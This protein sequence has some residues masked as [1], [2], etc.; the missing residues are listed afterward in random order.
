MGIIL[1][2]RSYLGLRAQG[3]GLSLGLG[4]RSA[5]ILSNLPSLTAWTP[6]GFFGL[7]LRF[8]FRLQSS[9]FAF[10]SSLF[11]LHIYLDLLPY[12]L[13]PTFYYHFYSL[14]L[15]EPTIWNPRALFV[16]VT[17]RRRPN[18]GDWPHLPR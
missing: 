9:I 4:G 13:L 7:L 18:D 17:A 11:T 16:F 6:R 14:H 5:D 12:L 8:F 10:P 1:A 3:S 2:E 15:T